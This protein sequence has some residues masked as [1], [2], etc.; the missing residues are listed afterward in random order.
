MER[1]KVVIS[2]ARWGTGL[3]G[4]YLLNSSNNKMCCLGFIC[5]QVFN[6]SADDLRDRGTYPK[7]FPW[8]R[9]NFSEEYDRISNKA[10]R[11][12]DDSTINDATREQE[13]LELFADT[14]FDI[15]FED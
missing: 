13:L 12:N 4:G 3:E 5:E 11:I 6:K 1:I 8:A 9:N 14:P 15:S 10:A 7:E 2:R